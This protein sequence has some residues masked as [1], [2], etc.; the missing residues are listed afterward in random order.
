MYNN[1]MKLIVGLGNP[2]KKYEKTRHNV[3][4]ET[5]DKFA[6]SLGID[7]DKEGYKGLYVR[8]KFYDEQLVLLKPQTFMNNSGESIQEISSYFKIE[9][10]DIYVIHDDMDF[11]PGTLKMK[12]SGSAAGHNGIKSVI[13]CLNTDEF[14][15]VRI[16]IGKFENDI[17]DYVLSKPSKE[18]RQLIDEAEDR[19]IEAIK[20]SLKET[21]DKAMSLYNR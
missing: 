2:G 15:H 16:G 8:T 4:F 5:I 10:K 21:I 14:V 6:N 1:C 7:I 11:N 12:T 13:Q 19:A 17:V 9:P 3:G 20:C 18:D